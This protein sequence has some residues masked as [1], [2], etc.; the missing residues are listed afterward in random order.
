MIIRKF[1]RLLLNLLK[2]ISFRQWFW[3]DKY[4]ASYNLAAL[5]ML[6]LSKDLVGSVTVC[7]YNCANPMMRI[8]QP[9]MLGQSV[10]PWGLGYH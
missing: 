2:I 4:F 10:L 3:M 9:P 6:H 5:E 8:A 1:R 7:P